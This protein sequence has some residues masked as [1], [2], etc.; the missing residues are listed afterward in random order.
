[1]RGGTALRTVKALVALGVFLALSSCYA[2]DNFTSELRL[3]R[4]GDYELT[5]DGDLLYLPIL[6]DY[7]H[8]KVDPKDEPRRLKEIRD[9]LVRDQAVKSAVSEGKG[10]FRV[11]YERMG[12]L[13]RDQLTAILR[14]DARILM[15]KSEP[16]NRIIVSANSLRPTDADAMTEA[17]YTIHGSFRITTDAH[18]ISNNATEVRSFGKYTVYIW[19]IENAL[20]PM[21][22]LVMIR[23]ADPQRPLP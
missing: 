12:R 22:Y 23:D 10:R 20:S 3:S 9:D 6:D 15:L 7:Q 8:G 14:R 1:M 17:G 2:P 19:N 21:P 11:H 13:G 4:F 16:D 5:F 18:V